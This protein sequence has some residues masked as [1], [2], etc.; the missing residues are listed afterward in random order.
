MSIKV[1]VNVAEEERDNITFEKRV[2][3]FEIDGGCVYLTIN[4]VEYYFDDSTG[5]GIVE[6][7]SPFPQVSETREWSRINHGGR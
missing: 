4:G 5:E 2:A 1:Q 6:G 3:S 7:N